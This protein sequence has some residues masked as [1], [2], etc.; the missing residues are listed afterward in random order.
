MY[1]QTELNQL[2]DESLK[3]AAE[4][5]RKS[6]SPTVTNEEME[7]TPFRLIG[8]PGKYFAVVGHN[9]I[10]EDCPTQSHVYE[11]IDNNHWKVVTTLIQ[12]VVN[13]MSLEAQKQMTEQ[14]NQIIEEKRKEEEGLPSFLNHENI[15]DN[16]KSNKQ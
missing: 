12:A 4:E 6:E 14:F 16:K 13:Q 9:K 2:S 10:T 3:S 1:K 7:G 15:I 11:W 5:N 8:A